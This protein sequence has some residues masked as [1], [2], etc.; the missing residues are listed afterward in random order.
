M[1]LASSLSAL[2]VSSVVFS[3]ATA[4]NAEVFTI[5]SSFTV[6]GGNSPG[7][8][9]QSVTLAPGTTSLDGGALSLTISFVPVGDA[10][11]SE[12]V[13]FSYQTTTGNLSQPGQNWSINQ[14]GLVAAVPVNFVGDFTQFLNSTGTA[15]N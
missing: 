15:F 14:T 10:A 9:S 3:F 12:W 7:S 8:F 4:A 2:A 6:S 13:V 5:G 11:Q 1:R